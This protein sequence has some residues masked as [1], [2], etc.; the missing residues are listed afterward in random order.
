MRNLTKATGS[1]LVTAMIFGFV[2][3]VTI[4]GIVYIVRYNLLSVKSLADQETIITAEQQYIQSVANKKSIK[5]K[6]DKLGN[7]EFKNT[8]KSRQP[9][10]SNKNVGI[11]LYN[12]QPSAISSDIVHRLI[13]KKNLKI[14]KDIIFKSLPKHS[15]V[16]YDSEFV[17][18][19]VPYV[20][21]HRMND[22]QRYYHLNKKGQISDS[23]VGYIGYI[24]KEYN[25]FLILVNDDVQVVSLKVSA[26][27]EVNIGWHLYKGRWQMLIA[28]Y[29]KDHL[30]IFRT[31]L[32]DLINSFDKAVLDISASVKIVDAPT[33]IAA[34]SWYYSKENSE[35]SLAVLATRYDEDGNATVMVEE[36]EYNKLRNTYMTS[37]KDSINGLGEIKDSNVYVEALDPYYTLSQSPLYVFAGDRLVAYNLDSSNKLS[38][39]VMV[40]SS[41]IKNK[42]VVV[43]KDD[44]SYYILAFEGNRYYQYTYA[45]DTDVINDA[46]PVVYPGNNIQ[47]ILVKYG[48]KLIV[49]KKK[50]YINDFKNKQLNEV[51]I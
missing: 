39:Q 7:F 50:L 16:N 45:K 21:I 46:K 30:Y 8:L 3:L 24:E 10:F 9:I 38:K 26:D 29:D 43:K 37:I 5:I 41:E 11:S 4:S 31:S 18:I 25:W 22:V 44:Y 32:D 40:L 17:P 13:Y 33:G 42:P 27:Y 15:M 35:P 47:N 36:L 23:K 2:I 1:S 20:D 14:T 12:A 48:V 6:K 28:V 34:V 51:S 19:N 49:T